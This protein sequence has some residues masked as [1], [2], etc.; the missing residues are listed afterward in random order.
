MMPKKGG[1]A[2]IIAKG[3]EAES[4]ESESEEGLDEETKSGLADE[5]KAARESKD[6]AA[7]I[8]ILA[9]LVKGL[10]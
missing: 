7:E 10:M 2:L 9:S 1:L 5:L 8:D 4:E 6:Y 3:K